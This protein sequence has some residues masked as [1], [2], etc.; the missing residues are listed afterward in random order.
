MG[1]RRSVEWLKTNMGKRN[2]LARFTINNP[3]RS[4]LAITFRN[5]QQHG[6][7]KQRYI[8]KNKLQRLIGNKTGGIN[9]FFRTHPEDV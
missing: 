9:A 4:M 7:C 3:D 5:G 1:L 8:G 2:R 6:Q